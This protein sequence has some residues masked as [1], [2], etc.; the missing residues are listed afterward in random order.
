MQIM[1]FPIFS[2]N[3]LPQTNPIQ[4]LFK[5]KI[6]WSTTTDFLLKFFSHHFGKWGACQGISKSAGSQTNNKS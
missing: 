4:P 6:F 5:I 2:E 3:P 1:Q